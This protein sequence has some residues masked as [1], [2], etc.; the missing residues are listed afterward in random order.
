MQVTGPSSLLQILLAANQAK[1]ETTVPFT[2]KPEA[3]PAPVPTGVETPVQSVQM[4]VAL[5]TM[6]PERAVERRRRMA[7]QAERG[8]DALEM[9]QAALVIGTGHGEPAAQLESWA[10]DRSP[11]DD[12]E[13]EE[14]MAEIDLRVQVELA[15]LERE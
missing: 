14:I 6:T 12:P 7:K 3:M 11:L 10:D 1:R 4:L 13:L 9:L 8:L 15:K 5:A 2:A